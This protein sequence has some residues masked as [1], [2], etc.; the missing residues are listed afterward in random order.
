VLIPTFN[1]VEA[2]GPVEKVK[3]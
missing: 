3:V 2:G 1:V